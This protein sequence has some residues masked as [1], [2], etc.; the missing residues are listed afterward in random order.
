MDALVAFDEDSVVTGSQ[1]GLIRLI[2]ILPNRMLGVLG[3]HDDLPV[4]SLAVN[5]LPL[6]HTSFRL[7]GAFLGNLCMLDAENSPL[8]IAVAIS[9]VS[10]VNHL[11]RLQQTLCLGRCCGDTALASMMISRSQ[12]HGKE[13]EFMCFAVVGR[14]CI[15]CQHKP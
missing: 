4:E 10:F 15:P 9:A 5:F 14:S 6:P 3:E 1:D 13:E 12:K 11:S 7:I 8:K 2:S